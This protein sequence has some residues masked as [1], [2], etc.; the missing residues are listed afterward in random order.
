MGVVQFSQ[1]AFSDY[2]RLTDA[3]VIFSAQIKYL[4]FYSFFFQNNIFVYTLLAWFLLTLIYLLVKGPRDKSRRKKSK[5][6]KKDKKD[7][8]NKKNKKDKKD[9]PAKKAQKPPEKIPSTL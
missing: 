1:L 3:E 4:T 9:K 6:G 7:K 5:S 2:A 8:R